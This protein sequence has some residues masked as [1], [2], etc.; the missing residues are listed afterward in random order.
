MRNAKSDYV[1]CA[2]FLKRLQI[3]KDFI[4]RVINIHPALIPAFCGA[5][6]YGHHVH[7]AVIDQGAK[8]SGCTVHFVDDQYDHGPIIAQRAVPVLDHDTASSLA[9]R[10]FAQECEI[11]PTVIRWLAESRVKVQGQQVTVT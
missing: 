10:V 7:E 11:H 3:P 5:G 8:I 1:V 9:T 6:R 4:N 2:G